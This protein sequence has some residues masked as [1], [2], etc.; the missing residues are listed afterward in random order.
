MLSLLQLRVTAIVNRLEEAEAFVLAG[1]AAL[2]ARG[3]IDRMT[4]DLDYF[5]RSADDVPPLRAALERALEAD[6]LTATTIRAA[7]GFARILVSDGVSTTEVDLAH[8]FR[9]LPPRR[10]RLA[11]ARCQPG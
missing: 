10:S 9:L 1:G 4:R 5:A 6:G 2:I 3:D 8:D 7:G 11:P